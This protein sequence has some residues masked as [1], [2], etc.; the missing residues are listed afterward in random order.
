M[1]TAR[2]LTPKVSTYFHDNGNG[3]IPSNY[4]LGT[5]TA[6]VTI[7]PDNLVDETDETNNVWTGTFEVIEPPTGTVDLAFSSNLLMPQPSSGNYLLGYSDFY[8]DGNVKN[9]GEGIANNVYVNINVVPVSYKH[10]RAHETKATL[11]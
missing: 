11:E 1:Y 7:D 8:I 2:S 4:P 5:Y 3:D 9:S 6:T 10:L